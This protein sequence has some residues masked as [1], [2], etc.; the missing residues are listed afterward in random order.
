MRE[1]LKKEDWKNEIYS[2]LS[3]NDS[4]FSKKYINRLFLLNNQN[5]NVSEKIFGLLFFEIWRRKFKPF[6]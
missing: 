5:Y 3:S 4:I 1:N 2:F 6:I